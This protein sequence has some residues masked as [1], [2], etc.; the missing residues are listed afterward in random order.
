MNFRKFRHRI[1]I[2]KPSSTEDNMGGRK[3]VWDDEF[4]TW[5][6]I[7]PKAGKQRSEAGRE[8]FEEGKIVARTT[9]FI[10]MRYRTDFFVTPAKR[11]KY[12]N[13]IFHIVAVTNTQELDK[14]MI[15]HVNEVVL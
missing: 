14:E 15:L 13:R 12:K 1:T 8:R 6:R 5:A 9:H 3:T 11:V 4:T 2:Q 10:E 7:T